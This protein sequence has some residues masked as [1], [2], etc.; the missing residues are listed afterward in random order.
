LITLPLDIAMTASSLCSDL[1]N[2]SLNCSQNS[3]Q[4]LQVTLNAIAAG[5]LFGIS[6]SNI[7]N[8]GS[9]KPM[10]GSFTFITKTS[11]QVSTFASGNYIASADPSLTNS[12]A[13]RF[14]D[15]QYSFSPGAYGTS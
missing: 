11:D 15:V 13:S 10:S 3:Y 12:I 7:R 2:I 8:A 14:T 1:T 9:Y 6:V 4:S 5:T